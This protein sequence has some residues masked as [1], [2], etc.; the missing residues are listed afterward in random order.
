M[1]Q[2]PDAVAL[3]RKLLSFN[4]I[5]PPGAEEA[6][7]AYLGSLL[8]AAGFHV[9]YAAFAPTRT[10]LVARIGRDMD[11][12]P[13]GFTGHMDTVPLGGAQWKHDAFG[14]SLEGGR[15]YG[16]GSSDMKSGV[17]GFVVAAL[18]SAERLR[19][20]PG[21]TLVLTADEECGCGGAAHLARQTTLL[22]TVG[23]LLVGEPT[24]NYPLVGHKGALWLEARTS[25]VTAH[26]SM[27]ERGD[28]AIYKAVTAVDALRRFDFGVAPHP[29]MGRPTL[30]VGTLHGGLNVN[31]VPDRATIG[32]DIRTIPGQDHR[33]LR[34]RLEHALG[35]AV[36]IAPI[37]DV[38]AVYSDPGGEWM[39][40]VFATAARTTGERPEPRSASYFTDAAVLNAVYRNVPIC[41]LGP[42]EP[43]LAHQTDEHCLVDRVE[44]SVAIYAE[45]I[46]QWN[47]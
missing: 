45:L 38:E 24:A 20:S 30:N 6:C 13:L 8:E 35:E 1:N 28:N 25:G 19:R 15:L 17:A 26:G 21:V 10:S 22:G 29:L 3:T 41:V 44:Q 12:P 7:A 16:R 43:Q 11:K 32:I 42:G 27:P 23:A 39:Q 36:E 47:Q 2:A 34:S 4:T 18:A 9:E 40:Q 31:S 33:A 14:A 5:N 46:R 37:V